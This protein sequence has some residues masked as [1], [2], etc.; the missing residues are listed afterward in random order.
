MVLSLCFRSNVPF[1]QSQFE[2]EGVEDRDEDYHALA[3]TV[4]SLMYYVGAGK[5]ERSFRVN[6]L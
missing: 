4:A 6:V 3:G 5:G 2:S 1:Q